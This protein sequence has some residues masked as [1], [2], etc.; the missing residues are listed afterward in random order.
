M[1]NR[2]SIGIRREDKNEWEKRVPLV[3]SDVKQLID[4][5]GLRFVVQPSRNHRAF[6][7][8]D[9]LEGGALIQEDLSQCSVILGV[10]EI[11]PHFFEAEKNYVMFSHVIKGQPYNMPML[12]TL[13]DKK[14]SLID[15]EKIEDSD[16]RRLIF[17]GRFAGLA[18]MV[19]TLRA[20]GIRLKNSGIRTPFLELKQPKDYSS[21]DAIKAEVAKIGEEIQKNGLP[22]EISPFICGFAGYGHV[23]QGAQEIFDL[24]PSTELS[25][26]EI[27]NGIDHLP[28]NSNGVYKVVFYEKD[29]F[30]P[31]N[32]DLPFE[33]QD[34]FT[35]PGKYKSRFFDYYPQLN[36]LV[37]CIYWTDAYPRLITRKQLQEMSAQ[38]KPNRLVI[39]GDISC[40]I[41]GAIEATVKSTDIAEP[42]F[43]YQAETGKI[44]DGLEGEGLAVMAIENLPCEIPRDASSA[45][46]HVLSDFIPNLA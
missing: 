46:S 31:I 38:N 40:D 2:A 13:M 29:M 3:P 32:P 39:V 26:T 15:Y 18:G 19:E 43:V 22:D 8:S 20:L 44:Q 1:T 17:F 14:C 21:L 5:H 27:S 12:K 23:S 33:L 42:C 9:Y 10:K 7:D 4:R 30:V 41:D 36:A 11:P 35:N 37:N 34:Y 24:L 45:F 6:P 16:G 25:P 28:R